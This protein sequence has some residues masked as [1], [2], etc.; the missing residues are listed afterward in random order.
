MKR[1]KNNLPKIL[2][3]LRQMTGLQL[4]VV[5]LALILGNFVATALGYLLGDFGNQLNIWVVLLAASST[6]F[7]GDEKKGD[8]SED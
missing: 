7:I 2:A 5:I 8:D 4:R 6:F 1:I 3:E